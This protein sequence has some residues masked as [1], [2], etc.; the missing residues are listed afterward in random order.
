MSTYWLLIKQW[1]NE[2]FST[3]LFNI[4]G[5][6]ISILWILKA[7]M[8]L[9]FV[10]I[11]ARGFKRFLRNYLLVL[12]RIDEGTREVIGTLSSLGL[13]TLGYIIVLQ[14][15]GLDLASFAV[16]VGG[17]GVGIGFGLQEITR[18][19]VSGLTL[20]G[21][22][23]LKVGDLIE[24]QGHLGYIQEIS[25]RSTVIKTF[26]GSQLVIPNTDLTS[27]PVE[28][29][30]YENCQG[31]IEISI[32]V[33]YN[34]D[35]LLVTELLL[36]SA[37]LE[38][39]V[40]SY[41]SPKVVFVEYG[42]NALIFELWV[43]VAN[44]ENRQFIKSSLNFIIEYKFRQGGISIPFPQRELWLNNIESFPSNNLKTVSNEQNFSPHITLKDSLKSFTCFQHLNE[45]ELRQLIE[46]GSRRHLNKGEIFI[47]KGEYD[48]HFCIVL[49][50][51]IQAIYETTKVSRLLF[52]FNQGQYF[53][54]LP[55][56]LEIP[57]PT[58]M[59]AAEDTHLFLLGKTCFEK[60][61]NQYP[62]L[63]KEIATELAKRQETLDEYQNSLKEMGLIDDESL[64]NPVVWIRERLSK[65][66]NL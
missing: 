55:L 4:G 49:S 26:Q 63:A 20:L 17:L 59:I 52:T 66:F 36:E 53:G 24:F 25:L 62:Y 34:S 16:V 40:L 57:Y 32:G 27:Q 1:F 21:E 22:S 65:I 56:L 12:F 7:I 31:R 64:K 61:L 29:W 28:N 60:L 8:L 30:N 43:W 13:G 58:T 41:P 45:L 42:D 9:I 3:P 14:G 35:L 6:E 39:E 47:Q 10:S 11:L 33:A 23:K 51:Q 48:S 44:I 19:L 38:Q 15:L 37:F 46:V 50:G 54:E 2:T 5:E 18:N